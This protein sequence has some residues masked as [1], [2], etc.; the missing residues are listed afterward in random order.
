MKVAV[1]AASGNLGRAIIN[2][3]LKQLPNDQIIGI[4]RT[5]EK[6]KDLGVE[7]RKGDYNNKADF[8]EALKGIDT[9]LIVSGMDAPDKRIK[10]HKGIIEAAKEAGVKKIVYTSII[11]SEE[12]NSFSPI[13]ASNRQTEKD[14][15]A[16]GLNWVIGRNGLYIEPDIEY[17]D[18]YKKDGKIANCAGG[19]KCSYTTRDELAFV[20]GQMILGEKH[21]GNIYNLGGT[22]ITQQELTQY[23]NEAFGTKLFY[24]SMSVEDYLAERK[25]KLGDFMGTIIAGIYTGI[26]NGDTVIESDFAKAAGR[27][28]ISWESYFSEIKNRNES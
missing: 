20:Y 10:Q 7:I 17:I 4:A 16:S 1:T 13:V 18:T 12:G 25:N 26:R 5:V 27:E 23:M 14:V 19:G 11:G 2:S 6:A 8:V 22:P 28:H 9:V 24:E 3:L 15:M 21:N